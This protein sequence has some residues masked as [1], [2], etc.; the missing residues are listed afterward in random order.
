MK[1]SINRLKPPKGLAPSRRVLDDPKLAADRLGGILASLF[2]EELGFSRGSL[3]E[4]PIARAIAADLREFPY[5]SVE[6]HWRTKLGLAAKGR[7]K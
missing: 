4:P 5:D 2:A 1:C 3:W 6:S 7:G